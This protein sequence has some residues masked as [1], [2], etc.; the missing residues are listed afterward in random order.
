MY[1]I[2]QMKKFLKENLSERRFIHSCNVSSSSRKLAEIYGVNPDIA[3]FAGLVHDICKEISN[4]K[5]FERLEKSN[6]D[7]CQEELS[8][9]KVWHGIAGAQFLRD[10]LNIKDND[11]LNAVRYHTVARAGMSELEK[12]VYL[13]DMISEE[14]SYTDVWQ[15]RAIT[16]K[17]L[18]LG[19]FYALRYMLQKL[20]QKG[21]LFPK[22]TVE[23]YHEY[24]SKVLMKG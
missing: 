5:Q 8:A 20:L 22:H 15:L 3:E 16:E 19:M 13:S 1:E 10:E 18:D 12:I 21:C 7:V 4:D 9:P 2:K 23:A 14:R 24:A 17:S 6:M 11:I